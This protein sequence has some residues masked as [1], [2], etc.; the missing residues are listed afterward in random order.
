MLA[1]ILIAGNYEKYSCRCP[2][3]PALT[4]FSHSLVSLTA[5]A[6]AALCL[7][8]GFQSLQGLG[9]SLAKQWHIKRDPTGG[10]NKKIQPKTEALPA[11]S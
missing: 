4:A 9:K 8:R 3:V 6:M 2:L 11:N 7:I 5:Q 1:K 10:M